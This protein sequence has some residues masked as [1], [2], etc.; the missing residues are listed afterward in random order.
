MFAKKNSLKNPTLAG[1]TGKLI[2]GTFDENYGAIQEDP[3]E[4]GRFGIVGKSKVRRRFE[5]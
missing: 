2:S 3:G 5:L 4:S 1:L